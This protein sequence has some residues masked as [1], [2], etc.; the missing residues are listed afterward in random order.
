MDGRDPLTVILSILAIGIITIFIIFYLV[1]S[2]QQ[3]TS[4]TTSNASSSSSTTVNQTIVAV[5]AQQEVQNAE[6]NGFT[7]NQ[8]VFNATS[9]SQCYLQLISGCDN[10]VPNQFICPNMAYKVELSQ[11]YSLT[12]PK[13]E[14]CPD[15]MLAGKL[16]CALQNG[17]CVVQESPG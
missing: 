2:A 7:V 16:G 14:I 1:G 4:T 11:Q 13:A 8:S 5:S 12:Y 3:S 17:R 10:N 9:A 6:K 15:Y